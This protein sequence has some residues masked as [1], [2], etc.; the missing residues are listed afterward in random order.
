MNR[1]RISIV[2]AGL[3]ASA[4]CAPVSTPPPAAASPAATPA[5]PPPGLIIREHEIQVCVVEN[6]A[7]REVRIGYNT[8][9]GDST[10][11]GQP[12][13]QVFPVTGEYA[14]AAQWYFDNEPIPWMDT[15]YV[16][17]GRTRELGAKDVT[18]VGEYRGVSVFV[19]T[20]TTGRPD[21][22]Y[23]PVRPTCEFQTYEVAEYGSAV[24][25]G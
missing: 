2:A 17:Y 25:G 24:R 9:T 16:K 15:R 3:F 18:R 5:P 8:Q 11:N 19:E 6:G 10:Y 12:F 20:G 7:F 4:A 1:H 21:V 13:G 14:A 22:F 23:V